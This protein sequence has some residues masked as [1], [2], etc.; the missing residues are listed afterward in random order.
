MPPNVS[1]TRRCF[2]FQQPLG[3]RL[4]EGLE[5]K[6]SSFEELRED[7]ERSSLGFD[8]LI[9]SFEEFCSRVEE[10]CHGFEVVGGRR[11]ASCSGGGG[12]SVLVGRYRMP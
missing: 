12:A 2:E 11:Y 6:C 3:H 9:A 7:L 10:S 8:E 4:L 5:A 1:F